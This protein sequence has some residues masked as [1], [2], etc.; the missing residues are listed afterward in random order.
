MADPSY[1]VNGVLTDGEAWVSLGTTTLGSDT[2]YIE[3]DS[4]DDGQVGDFSQYMDIVL[5]GYARSDRAVEV[6]D[7]MEIEVNSYSSGSNF[8]NQFLQGDGS[9]ATSAADSVNS[10]IVA[11]MPAA[12][13]TD[14][15]IFGAYVFHLFDINS[16][17]YTSMLHQSA[18]DLDGS[19]VVALYAQVLTATQSAVNK[20]RVKPRHGSN[21]VGGS[22][23]S[24]FGVLPRMVA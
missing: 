12:G 3:W 18:V 8:S 2:A 21:L 22:M 17:K 4:T 24:A 16:G 15:D 9:S 10:S 7:Y 13:T 6:L 19:G 20:I 23:F 1:I 5:I 11:Q 14:T